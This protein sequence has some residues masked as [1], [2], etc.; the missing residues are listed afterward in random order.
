MSRPSRYLLLAGLG[1]Q[2]VLLPDR[3]EHA[4]LPAEV[5]EALLLIVP[6]HLHGNTHT[7]G[8][9]FESCVASGRVQSE[10][11]LGGQ[12]QDEHGETLHDGGVLIQQQGETSQIPALPWKARQQKATFFFFF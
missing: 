4:A 5:S 2:D 1:L 9:C 10:A 7:H 8:L 6:V 11:H 3:V 12:T